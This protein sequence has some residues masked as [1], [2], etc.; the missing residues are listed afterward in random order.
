VSR[1]TA[2]GGGLAALLAGLALLGALALVA[3]G[4][5]S[6]AAR[7]GAG[8]AT[9]PAGDGGTGG[10]ARPAARVSGPTLVAVGD[11]ACAPGQPRQRFACHQA[12]TAALAAGLHPDAVALLGD[13]QYET[14]ALAD[15]RGSFDRTW[16]RFGARLH[17][18]LGNHEYGTPGAAGYFATFGARAGRPG[19]GWYSWNLGGWHLI[20][21]NANCEQVGCGAGSPQVRWLRA[22]LAQHP[23][24][25]TLAYWHQPRFSS[26]LHGNARDVAAL[27]RTLERAGADVVL[28]GHDHDYERFAPQDADG[29]S[30]PR[31]GIA[32]LVVGTGGRSLYP[33]L[34]ARANS[35]A[36]ASVFGV[37]R[38]TLGD[39]RYAWRFVAER[40]TR[41]RDAGT[42]RC[43]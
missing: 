24:R 10:T 28:S 16:G 36:R 18:A 23:T 32:E 1:R 35:R 41:F 29:R 21:L 20:A 5:G 42:A 7:A 30:D 15:F 8:T 3:C 2:P 38:L 34:F 19:E 11:V 25:C 22:D 27:W 31:H 26:G 4:G 33:T 40:G 37:L 12:D 9:A 14:G 6:S 39:G 43:R 17:P 13:L